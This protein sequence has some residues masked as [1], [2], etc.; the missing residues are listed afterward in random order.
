[1]RPPACSRLRVCSSRDHSLGSKE[2][3]L[4]KLT[5][6][7]NQETEFLKIRPPNTLA[8]WFTVAVP[9]IGVV[10]W[11]FLISGGPDLPS[12][13]FII[14][15]LAFAALVSIWCAVVGGPKVYAF[16]VLALIFDG[17]AFTSL[18]PIDLPVIFIPLG[19]AIPICLTIEL[20]KFMF[21]KFSKVLPGDE[22]FE[23]GLQ[24]KLSQMFITTTVIAILCGIGPV[25]G[26]HLFQD[27]LNHIPRI[28]LIISSVLAL[29]TLVSV[30]GILGKSM[31]WRLTILVPVVIGTV[32]LGS[33]WMPDDFFV[34]I[35][36]FGACSTAIVVLLLMLRREGY[37][38]VRK[39]IS[40]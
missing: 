5:C 28:V 20:I 33:Y 39:P 32:V 38:F 25:V 15:L 8:V 13:C 16:G 11:P 14:S 37:R 12:V 29:N 10:S 18:G 36:V 17:L 4:R 21:G 30:W 19:I 31:L 35:T 6:V 24:F 27:N 2:K 34:W 1:M 3:Y 22:A 23:E 26:K 40:D 9:L 7:P